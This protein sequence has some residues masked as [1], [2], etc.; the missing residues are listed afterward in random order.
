[1]GGMRTL[2]ASLIH[3]AYTTP[4]LREHILPLLKE[5]APPRANAER[6]FRSLQAAL[7]PFRDEV[8]SYAKSVSKIGGD[9]QPMLD[10]L[11]KLEA[12]ITSVA[13]M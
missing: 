6:N 5:A 11:E 12:A 13:K 10:A 7:G 2:R 3:L 8:T 1:M 9:P 4:G